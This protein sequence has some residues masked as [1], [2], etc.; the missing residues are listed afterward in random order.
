MALGTAVAVATITGL[1]AGAAAAEP[2][3][4]TGGFGAVVEPAVRAVLPTA[5][6]LTHDQ[7]ARPDVG[8]AGITALVDTAF[9]N[10]GPR[11]SVLVLRQVGA[12]PAMDAATATGTGTV[13]AQLRLDR[14]GVGTRPAYVTVS[15]PAGHGG[16][17]TVQWTERT[18]VDYR[19][20][21][22][23]DVTIADLESIARRVPADASKP[24]SAA[25]AAVPAATAAAT[26]AHPGAAAAPQ[27]T[28]DGYVAGAGTPTD[29]LGDEATLCDGCSSWNSNY[30][31]LWQMV[32]GVDRT[33]LPDIDCQFGPQTAQ[34]TAAWQD[35][36]GMSPAQQTGRLDAPTRDRV[37][38]KVEIETTVSDGSD[39]AM[40]LGYWQVIN[41]HR[42]G[43]NLSSPYRWDVQSI[44]NSNDWHGAAYNYANFAFC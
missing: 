37:D 1:P 6:L 9:L 35:D 16:L 22:R 43:P 3:R 34:Y 26:A 33:I 8:A 28:S 11:A 7:V 17:V 19:V 41:I 12:V 20:T 5:R 40:Y 14:P 10:V 4:E 24:T 39:Y 21:G 18:G 25:L 23:G 44:M 29:D 38:N 31:A 36:E 2:A 13:T 30:T 32:L 15:A 27:S 42:R